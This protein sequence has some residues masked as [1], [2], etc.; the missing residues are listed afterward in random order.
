[1]EKDLKEYLADV[2]TMMTIDIEEGSKETE[3]FEGGAS[4]R[5]NHDNYAEYVSRVNTFLNN[6]NKTQVGAM[7]L[8]LTTCIPPWILC[9]CGTAII[10]VGSSIKMKRPYKCG[11]TLTATPVA[12]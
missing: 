10:Q 7:A 1:M 5:V 6:N 4:V 3:L 12:S 8:G 9:E 11:V 2:P